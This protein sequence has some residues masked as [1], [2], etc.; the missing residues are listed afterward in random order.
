MAIQVVRGNRA[1]WLA[2]AGV[3]TLAAGIA[4]TLLLRVPPGAE[5]PLAAI[6]QYVAGIRAKDGSALR[7]VASPEH[8][9]EEA[10]R[11]LTED[12]TFVPV[13]TMSVEWRPTATGKSGRA[14]LR[15]DDFSFERSIQLV[16]DVRNRWFVVFGE[17]R[18]EREDQTTSVRSR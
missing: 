11:K 10:I 7:G 9:S 1:R 5:S 13:A 14:L 16:R 4:V 8:E 2:A 18:G 12:P 3:L 17:S 15:N 6:D